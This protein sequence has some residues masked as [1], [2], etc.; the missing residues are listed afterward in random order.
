MLVMADDADTCTCS[1]KAVIKL[2][3]ADTAILV[4][5]NVVTEAPG[6]LA[7][8]LALTNPWASMV[9]AFPVLAVII[10]K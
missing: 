4:S 6:V 10:S 8:I 3:G 1:G 2:T 5:L 9:P 7:D